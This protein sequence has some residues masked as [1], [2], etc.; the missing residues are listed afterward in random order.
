MIMST[1]VQVLLQRHMDMVEPK[2]KAR[3]RDACN[4]G[5]PR[6][7]LELGPASSVQVCPADLNEQQQ[8]QQPRSLSLSLLLSFVAGN[9]NF[10]E[11]S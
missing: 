3:Y 8:Q 7:A 2:A 6:I 1:D 4:A 10:V 9:F 11:P 5:A